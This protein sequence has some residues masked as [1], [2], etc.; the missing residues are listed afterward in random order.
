MNNPQKYCP[1][2]SI[3]YVCKNSIPDDWKNAPS[4]QKPFV[5]FGFC[6]LD[7]EKKYHEINGHRIRTQLGAMRSIKI[8]DYVTYFENNSESP[9]FETWQTRKVIGFDYS[10]AYTTYFDN[11]ERCPTFIV[12]GR[13]GR[14]IADNK[15][16]PGQPLYPFEII[17]TADV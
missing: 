6:G 1:D 12:D 13:V 14:Q 7:C 8:G 16:L 3:C 10:G 4:K 5:Y 17:E 11:F 9:Q 15:H 2:D